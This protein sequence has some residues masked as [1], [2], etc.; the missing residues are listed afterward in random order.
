MCCGSKRTELKNSLSTAVATSNRPRAGAQPRTDSVR[1]ATAPRAYAP[2]VIAAAQ[3]PV[4]SFGLAQAG[5]YIAIS[6]LEKAP[7]RVRGLSTGR[8]YEFSAANPMCEVD[9]RDASALLN[10]RFFRRA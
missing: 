3:P 4:P 1:T 7:V 2:P 9:K 6:Y 5:S 10:T 8:V